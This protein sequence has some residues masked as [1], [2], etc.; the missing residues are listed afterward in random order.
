MDLVDG[1]PFG[2]TVCVIEMLA[3]QFYLTVPSFIPHLANHTSGLQTK[4]VN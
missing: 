3:G 2:A 4:P 1:K